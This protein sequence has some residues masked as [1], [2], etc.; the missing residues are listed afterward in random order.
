MG[1]C[2]IF[3]SILPKLAIMKEEEIRINF[4][5]NLYA[6]RKSRNLSQAQLAEALN[7]TYKAV[8]KWENKE[9]IPD[10]VTLTAISEYFDITVNDLISNKDVVKKSNK[11]KNRRRIT[12]S[13]IGICFV[14]TGLVYLALALSN[15]EK[16]YIV[17]PFAALTSGIVYLVFS[18]IWF[19]K[20][21]VFLGVTII[22]WSAAL[23]VMLFMNFVMFWLILI[24]A[25]TINVAFYPFLRI[26]VGREKAN[27]NP[28]Q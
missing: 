17:I 4:S 16:A 23:I 27:E 20:Y 25:G 10:I 13:S 1:L 14:V 2:L 9:T 15:I 18:C 6:L 24:I 19:K 26:F 5:K 8:S 11:K 28:L 22:I 21:H 7:Y 12:L 3:E